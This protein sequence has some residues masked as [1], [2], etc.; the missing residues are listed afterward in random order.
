MTSRSKR[1]EQETW[2]KLHGRAVSGAA[3][4]MGTIIMPFLA[5]MAWI[6]WSI[7]FQKGDWSQIGKMESF[8]IPELLAGMFAVVAAGCL[9]YGLLC[10]RRARRCR[11]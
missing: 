1:A 3:L 8:G 4:L 7:V 9:V 6:T 10:W 5:I 2:Q 11:E